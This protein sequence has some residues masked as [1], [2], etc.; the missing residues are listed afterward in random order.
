MPS[1]VAIWIRSDFG[2]GSRDTIFWMLAFKFIVEFYLI[3][4]YTVVVR[5]K[6]EN[7]GQT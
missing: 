5:I 4:N 7:A 2:I 3:D 6:K 1:S